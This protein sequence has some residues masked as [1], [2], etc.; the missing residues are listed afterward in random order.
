MKQSVL[1]RRRV[2]DTLLDETL[3]EVQGLLLSTR[4][5]WHTVAMET[6]N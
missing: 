6:H 1:S 5:Q 4:W 2:E 3:H